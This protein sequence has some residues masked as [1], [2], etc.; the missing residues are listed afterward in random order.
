MKARVQFNVLGRSPKNSNSNQKIES[1]VY[2]EAVRSNRAPFRGLA[3]GQRS[4]EF[5]RTFAV[6]T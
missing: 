4:F 2:A 1:L 6:G 3:P 5:R